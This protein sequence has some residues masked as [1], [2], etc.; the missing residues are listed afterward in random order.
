MKS[1]LIFLALAPVAAFAQTVIYSENFESTVGTALPAGWTVVPTKFGE[2]L[3]NPISAGLNT[4]SRVLSFSAATQ[5]YDTFST[6]FDL[7]A[8]KTNGEPVTLSF[9]FLSAASS[10]HAGLIGLRYQVPISADP[11]LSSNSGPPYIAG[12][13]ATQSSV[14]VTTLFSGTGAWQHVTVDLS[15]YLAA[16][17][18]SQLQTSYIYFEKWTGDA[19][20]VSSANVYFDNLVVSAVPEPSAF[21]LCAGLTIA[22]VAIIRRRLLRMKV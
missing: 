13:P 8:Y 12:S 21:G 10:D 11:A 4:S 15:A 17:T 19:G 14:N 2:S 1:K 5:D 20:Q 16:Q 6:P 7:S 3:A 18:F 22:S 9:D